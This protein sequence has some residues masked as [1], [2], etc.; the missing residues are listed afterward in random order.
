MQ[1]ASPEQR[2]NCLMT[3]LASLE[4]TTTNPAWCCICGFYSVLTGGLETMSTTPVGWL[5]KSAHELACAH[6]ELIRIS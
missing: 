2:N 4:D 3:K 1:I 6:K 5:H